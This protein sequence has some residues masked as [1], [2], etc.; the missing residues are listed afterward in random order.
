[1]INPLLLISAAGALLYFFSGKKAKA[2]GAVKSGGNDSVTAAINSG[3]GEAMVAVMSMLLASGRK[4]EPAVA[5]GI[6]KLKL[7]INQ[8]QPVKE[9]IA[10]RSG[11]KYKLQV[12]SV[13]DDGIVMR[14]VFT[15][16]G[17][18]IVRFSQKMTDAKSPKVFIGNPPTVD[19]SILAKAIEDFAITKA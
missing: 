13:F 17:A 10:G 7:A 3:D 6:A 16:T 11:R 9:V 18:R 12:V 15:P 2:S 4:Q 14:D 19:P 5:N 8:K 1:M